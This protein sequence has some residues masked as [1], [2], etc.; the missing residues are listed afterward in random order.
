MMGLTL[1]LR[2]LRPQF[3]RKRLDFAVLEPHE[4]LELLHLDFEDLSAMDEYLPVSTKRSTLG[5][6]GL[7]TWMVS[8]S[9]VMTVSFSCNS[10]EALA[11]TTDALLEASPID[12]PS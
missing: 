11:S 1:R 4:L 12:G 3:G 7:A 8:R 2:L 10:S 6:N 5:K 9:S